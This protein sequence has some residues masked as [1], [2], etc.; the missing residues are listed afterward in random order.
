MANSPFTPYVEKNLK[1]S[2]VEVS[3]ALT[4][5]I[6]P[7]LRIRTTPRLI[8]DSEITGSS[9]VKIAIPRNISFYENDDSW[10]LELDEFLSSIRGEKQI[11]QFY[12][13]KFIFTSYI[14][15]LWINL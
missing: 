6:T 4:R 2:T 13:L 11:K 1:I 8:T 15:H 14:L 7:D 5:S 10:D 3:P 12:E 9:A